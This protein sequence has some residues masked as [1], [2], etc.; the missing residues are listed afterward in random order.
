MAS[1][2]STPPSSST[3]APPSPSVPRLQ[4]VSRSV[5]G[6]VTFQ[7]KIPNFLE[8][9]EFAQAA[10]EDRLVSDT[11]RVSAPSHKSKGKHII[12]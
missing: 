8:E 6:E 4:G 9:V 1:S 3:L 10:K 12:N 5:F 11:F 7:W 2:S